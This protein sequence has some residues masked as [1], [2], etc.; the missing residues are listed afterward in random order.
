M[1]EVHYQVIFTNTELPVAF[2]SQYSVL[3]APILYTWLKFESLM[4]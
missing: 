3:V 4:L 2:G 1:C